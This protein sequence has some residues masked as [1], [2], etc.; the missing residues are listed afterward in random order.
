MKANNEQ[1]SNCWP[2][3]LKAGGDGTGTDSVETVR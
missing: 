3:L 1:K 2:Q